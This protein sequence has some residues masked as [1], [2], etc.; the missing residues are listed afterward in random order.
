[1]SEA[2]QVKAFVHEIGAVV[3]RFRSEF[4][5]TVAAAIGSLEIVKLA[6][7]KEAMDDE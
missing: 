4:D 5:L 7:F 3:D 1:M 2:D 6:L